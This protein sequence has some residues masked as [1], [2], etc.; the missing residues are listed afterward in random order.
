MFSVFGMLLCVP[1]LTQYNN[2]EEYN[3]LQ[4]TCGNMDTHTNA[5]DIQGSSEM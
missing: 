1:W 5:P 3:P 2:L 4:Q